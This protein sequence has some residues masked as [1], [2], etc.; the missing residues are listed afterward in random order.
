M[1]WW[2]TTSI[3]FAVI[4]KAPIKWSWH[5]VN[6]SSRKKSLKNAL[7]WDVKSL[8]TTQRMRGWVG[9]APVVAKIW[10][11]KLVARFVA[12]WS[13]WARSKGT[14]TCF[15]LILSTYNVKQQHSKKKSS[16]TSFSMMG[17]FDGPMLNPKLFTVRPLFLWPLCCQCQ[18][19]GP[20]C[21]SHWTSS[22]NPQSSA[23]R[24]RGSWQIAKSTESKPREAAKPTSSESSWLGS[25]KRF[26]MRNFGSVFFD[27]SFGWGLLN[28]C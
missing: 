24:W 27:G 18:G 17:G 11:W 28:K 12:K 22:T 15:F 19:R 14:G 21:C 5:L 3:A 2:P 6:F 16:G 23:Q 26:W 7:G 8:R 4:L 25:N 10:P 9:F 20:S 1:C 13:R